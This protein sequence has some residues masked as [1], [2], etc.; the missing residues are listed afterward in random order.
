MGEKDY[1]HPTEIKQA[2]IERKLRELQ[3]KLIRKRT[4]PSNKNK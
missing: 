1:K 2:E 3:R 4:Y